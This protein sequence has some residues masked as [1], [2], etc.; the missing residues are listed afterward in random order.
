VSK[1]LVIVELLLGDVPERALFRQPGLE[2]PLRPYL[3]LTQVRGRERERESV[4]VCERERESRVWFEEG[5]R[6]RE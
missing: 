1:S 5:T 4:C 3:Q 2:R 6:E